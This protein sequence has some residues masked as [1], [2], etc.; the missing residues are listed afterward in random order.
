MGLGGET[1][2]EEAIACY[3]EAIIQRRPD[4]YPQAMLHL[5]RALNHWMFHHR[6]LE[7][8]D[9][10]QRN[11]TTVANLQE[12]QAYPRYLLSI[13]YRLGAEIYAENGVVRLVAAN[14][15][16]EPMEFPAS[17]VEVQGVVV[18]LIRRY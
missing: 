5:G 3:R 10:T 6:L 7:R 14:P 13:A 9:E 2:E 12:D 18:G 4:V 1:A 11:L 16:V 17:D 15:L 8:F